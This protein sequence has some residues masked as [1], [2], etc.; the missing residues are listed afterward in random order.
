MGLE[1]VTQHDKFA[2]LL[3]IRILE[4]S[5]GSATAELEI[6]EQHLNGLGWVH[7]GVIVTLADMAFAAAANSQGV[8]AVAVNLNVSFLKSAKSGKLTAVATEI[9]LSR[10]L[11]TYRIEVNDSDGKPIASLQGTA[12]RFA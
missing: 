3:G 1:K 9:S 6:K 11:G 2:Q 12:Y 10:R 4:A 8:D 7:G 5:H